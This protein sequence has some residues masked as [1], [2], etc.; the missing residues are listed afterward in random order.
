MTNQELTV[1][2]VVCVST[3]AC[4]CT[5]MCLRIYVSN[6]RKDDYVGRNGRMTHSDLPFSPFQ[7][8]AG[9]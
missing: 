4:A 5:C 6:L 9:A 3:H 1:C 2:D 7:G 8:S